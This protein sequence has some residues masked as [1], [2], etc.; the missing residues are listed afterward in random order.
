MKYNF[1]FPI[2]N[3]SSDVLMKINGK[4]GYFIELALIVF[5]VLFG[6]VCGSSLSLELSWSIDNNIIYNIKCLQSKSLFV[7]FQ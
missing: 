4:L 1:L 2:V 5:A 3:L 6:D 7:C